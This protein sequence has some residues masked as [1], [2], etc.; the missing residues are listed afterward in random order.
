V[1]WGH[2]KLITKAR[3]DENAKGR[4]YESLNVFHFVLS[5]FRG[6]VMKKA[7]TG[8]AGSNKMG[9]LPFVFPLFQ[10]GSEGDFFGVNREW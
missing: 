10:R 3:K 8:W 4:K 5:I 2:K 1:G 7:L 6:F 9:V